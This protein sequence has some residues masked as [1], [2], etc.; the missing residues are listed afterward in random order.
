VKAVERR[1]LRHAGAARRH[2][3]HAGAIGAADAALLV[4][5]ASLIT[6]LVV[7][8]LRG[9]GLA[10]MRGP[11]LALAGVVA[12]RALL[13]WGGQ[14][15]AHS[16]SAR[17]K[18]QL[19]RAVL[20]HITQLGPQW[21]ATQS[22]G[23]VATLATR[24]TDA[25][26]GY[27]ARYLPALI[28]AALVPI[29]VT[30][31]VFVRDPVSG[32]IIC[33]TL[34]LVPLFGILVG[35]TAAGRARRQWRALAALGGH[36]LD[37]VEGLTTLLV[38]R[39][40]EAQAATI[41]RVAEEN[42]RASMGTLRL[43]FLSSAILEFLATICVALVAVSVGLRLVDGRL[44]LSTGLFAILLAPDA[45]WP[46]RQ[47]GAQFHASAEGLA[48]AEQLFAV[49][50]TPAKAARVPAPRRP[51]PD[52]ARSA[53][54]LEGLTVA[55][56]RGSAALSS[57]DLNLQPGEYVGVAGPSGC[58]KSTLLAVLLRFAAPTA[59]RVLVEGHDGM[60]DLAEIDPEAWRAQVAWVPQ[61]PW[62]AARSIAE[63]VRLARPAASDAQVAHA[64]HVA[65][66]SEFVEALPEGMSTVLG[67]GGAPL[68]AGQ[69]QR[70]ALAR[71]F[72]RDA[73]LVLLDEA[74][75]HLD[76]ASERAVAEA[77]R[78]LARERTVIAVAHRAALLADADRVI[79]L[80]PGFVGAAK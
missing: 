77:V 44:D 47:V 79:H 7:G 62:Y 36:F 3:A 51:A 23:D 66:A 4:I 30:A 26:D 5:Q 71:A 41:R 17:V 80:Q 59:G 15:A 2:V 12:G 32:L 70:I 76:A 52:L 57:L 55:Y 58:G 45:Y 13:A 40:A 9:A 42:R 60:V 68:S 63:N 1:L 27:F 69:R 61:N 22:V 64:L 56:D 31:V 49:L 21:L 50:E 43:A 78:R 33:L 54:R 25:L 35:M 10:Q 75:A 67:V 72:L 34:P 29:S 14:V 73:P 37:V 8:P 11:V 74:T 38:F 53:I 48:A 39:R 6:T 24:G 18:S 28:T 19:R 46:L 16:A 65:N 20:A